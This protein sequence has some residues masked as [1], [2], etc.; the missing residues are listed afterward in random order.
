VPAE[1]RSPVSGGG[2][3]DRPAVLAERSRNG[4]GYSGSELLAL[5]SAERVAAVREMRANG[6]PQTATQT[7]ILL[8]CAAT[9]WASIVRAILGGPVNDEPSTR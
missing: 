6:L 4:A 7:Y 5:S 3:G 1:A 9:S 8:A 2:D